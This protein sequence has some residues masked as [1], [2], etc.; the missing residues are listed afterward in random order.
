MVIR[1]TPDYQ[2]SPSQLIST[3]HPLIF[4]WT[5]KGFVSPES[6]FIFFLN[7][8]IPPWLQKRLLANTFVSH[9]TNTFVEITHSSLTAFSEDIF[10]SAEGR[11]GRRERVMELKKLPKL[12]L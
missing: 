7:L 4:L 1:H 2:P 8:Y 9:F 11:N 5:S 3:I 6:F 10:S 12:N